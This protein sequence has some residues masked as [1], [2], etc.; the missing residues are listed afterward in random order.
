M[1]V[2][3]AIKWIVGIRVRIELQDCEPFVCRCGGIDDWKQ[4]G[5][6]TAERKHA[7]TILDKARD[8][9]FYLAKTNVAKVFPAPGLSEVKTRLGAQI[10]RAAE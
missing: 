1:G 3:V 9:G 5:M 4:N 8:G 7:N 2:A 10:R 6:I